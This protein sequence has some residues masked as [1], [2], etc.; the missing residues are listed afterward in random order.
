MKHALFPAVALAVVGLAACATRPVC[1]YE[2]CPVAPY[3]LDLDE[4]DDH[5]HIRNLRHAARKLWERQQLADLSLLVQQNYDVLGAEPWLC[6]ALETRQEYRAAEECY[7]ARNDTRR[8]L[9][10]IRSSALVGESP[11]NVTPV[12]A[13]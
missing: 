9:R 4:A 6:L 7:M 5:E 11:P 8:A 3:G 10:A 13:D 12:T 2:T 1:T